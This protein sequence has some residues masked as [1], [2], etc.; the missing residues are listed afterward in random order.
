MRFIV[1]SLFVNNVLRRIYFFWRKSWRES[2]LLRSSHIQICRSFSERVGPRVIL[3]ERLPNEQ[4]SYKFSRSEITKHIKLRKQKTM[5]SDLTTNYDAEANTSDVEIKKSRIVVNRTSKMQQTT[6]IWEKRIL[7][8][9]T[10]IVNIYFVTLSLL[11]P[12]PDSFIC[13][14]F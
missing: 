4:S 3:V 2:H 1:R 7:N 6:S 10:L 9:A 11:T 13:F 12:L 14:C 5:T 8:E